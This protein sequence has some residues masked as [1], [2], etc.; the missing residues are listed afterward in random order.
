MCRAWG[1]SLSWE[2]WL[3]EGL[4]WGP[5]TKLWW[6]SPPWHLPGHLR[7]HQ[8]NQQHWRTFRSEWRSH[9]Q[10][11][12]EDI[13]HE[14][15]YVLMDSM[16]FLCD[17]L[18]RLW[19][20]CFT[21]GCIHH[22]ALCTVS[23]ILQL[24]ENRVCKSKAMTM[25]THKVQWWTVMMMMTITTMVMIMMVVGMMVVRGEASLLTIVL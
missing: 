6:R 23:I 15:A 21:G 9:K 11:I 16:A 1:W 4:N 13:V 3:M 20:R 2:A 22:T 17:H 14:C 5:T 18:E 19:S 7:W 10:M 24:S 12:C 8:S 25:E